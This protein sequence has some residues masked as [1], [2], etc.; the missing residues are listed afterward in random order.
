MTNN[1][2]KIKNLVTRFKDLTTLGFAN[3]LSSAISGIFWF[4]LASLLGTSNYGEVSYFIAIASIASTVSFLGAS[5]TVTVYT[6]KGEKILS[7]IFSVTIITTL[8]S[9]IILFLLFKNLGVSLYIIGSL[10][11]GL[12]TADILG[13]K[14]YNNYS[15]Y[16]ITQ[17]LLFVGFAL[18]FYYL[19]GPQGVILGYAVSFFPYLMR[20]YQGFKESKINISLLRPHT[21]FM[22]NSYAL[23]LSRTFSGNTDKLIVA[24]LLGFALLG[25][26]QLGMQFLSLLSLLPAIVY[27]YVLPHDAS[28]S[29]N[30]KLKNLTI[31]ISV[32]LAILGIMLAP[33]VLPILFPKFKEAI[34]VIQIISLTIV[35][36]TINLMYIS[37][38]LGTEKSRVVL[39][40]SGIFLLV[41]ISSILTFGKIYGVNG[42]AASLVL[43]ASSESIY[44]IIMNKVLQQKSILFSQNSVDSSSFKQ[45]HANL[46]EKSNISEKK[47]L[48]SFIDKKIG[49]FTRNVFL[50]L[51]V[52]GI[53]SFFIRLHYFPWDI[54]LKLDGL[55]YF[56]YAI[57]TSILGHLPTTST[58]A[59]NGWPVFLSMFFSIFHSNNF[60]DYMYLQRLVSVFISVVTIIPV[61]LLCKRFFDKQ[62]AILSTAIFAFEPR[63]IQNSLLGITEPLYIIMITI[64]LVLFFS[65]NK[66]MTYI[67][68]G[69]IAL[70]TLVRI[71]GLILFIAF[72]IM[73][74]VRFRKESKAIIKY[75]IAVSIF[76]LLLLPMA[77]F[78]IES[79]GH[80]FLTSRL[81]DEVHG[82]T[83]TH[84]NILFTQL[85][86]GSK[87]FVSLLGW[88]MI[89]IFIFF[90]PLGAFLIFK[91]RNQEN[92]T[93]I[94]VIILMLFASF[95][96]YFSLSSDT[97]YIYPLFPLFCILSLFTVKSLAN[98]IT[99]RDT[100]LVLLIGGILL[101][102]LVF[103]H[104]K[105]TDIEYEKEALST[106]YDVANLTSGINPDSTSSEYLPIIEMNGQ[107][108]PILSTLIPVG[109]KTI[110]TKGFESLNDYIKSGKENGLTH[111]VLD[112]SNRSPLFLNDVFYHE[113]NYPYLV[114]IYDSLN[115]H[116]KY[117]LK[118]YKINYEQFEAII[119]NK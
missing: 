85:I 1:L 68:F 45:T 63:I 98:R 116:Y 25:N 22:L 77:I 54:P 46:T 102:S 9:S 31:I 34:Q 28:G 83:S 65:S 74:F 13:R 37:K 36:S 47:S 94:I 2:N 81:S 66:K 96:A 75:S 39:I 71:E 6:A 3:I 61:Y 24:P 93:I 70:V 99:K 41:Q 112:G 64:S 59:N 109:P 10:I 4:Y 50:S 80:D 62:Y 57:D 7:S 11:F 82:I 14:L 91:K 38:F 97:R 12:A 43:A 19:I 95:Y 32:I 17:K 79:S 101:S 86:P 44:L 53:I 107:K 35:P 30:T 20:I 118:I 69:I 78:R 27:Q 117:H 72:S 73:F 106:S 16:L 60:M 92:I 40:G 29:S 51:L 76:L 103:L 48:T 15:K 119:G 87:I 33:K 108:F 49:F 90:V 105:T 5:T 88:S 100:C 23:D 104:L 113:E 89:P 56:F 52:I 111:L 8:I 26:Y 67:S 42:V 115:H 55:Q 18:S 84:E 110:T 21:G 114:K 58:I